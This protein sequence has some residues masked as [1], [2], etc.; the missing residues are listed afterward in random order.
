MNYIKKLL[1]TAA[2][3][4][5]PLT[6]SAQSS[7]DEKPKE[8]WQNLDLKADGA[9]GISTDKAYNELLK[10]KTSK[11]VVVAVIDGGIDEN[12]EDLKQVMWINAKEIAGNGIDDDKNGYIDD[13]YGWNFIGSAKGLNIHHD[14]MEVVRL[15]NKLQPKYAAALNST[16]FTEAE[17]KEFQLYKK[18]VTDYMEKLQQAQ[19]G[20]QNTTLI[21][22]YLNE[23]LVKMGKTEPTIEDFNAYKAAGDIESQVVKFLKP[24]IKKTSYKEFRQELEDGLKHYDTQIKYH[25]NLEFDPRKDSVGDNYANS[26]EKFYGNNDI[27][28]PDAEHGTHVAG[29]IGAVRGNSLGIKG[30]ADNVKIMALRTVPDGDER[31]KDVANSIRYAVDNGAKVINMSFGKAYSWDKKVVDEAVKY[32]VSKDVLLVHAA[33]NDGK[34]TEKEDNVPNRLFADSTGVTMGTAEGWIEVGASGWNNDDELVASFSNYGGKSVDVFAPG[35]KINSTMPDS[36]YKDNDGTSMASPVVA[37]LAA[38]IRSYY[39][40]FTA[41]QVKEIIMNSVTK[42]EQKVK[43]REEG[44]SNKVA[45]SEISVSGGVV[46]A[47]NALLLAEKT[48]STA[49]V[50]SK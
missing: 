46:N 7:A 18:L 47:Y 24:E 21:L 34:N 32:A 20:L 10:G 26:N 29:I 19:M 3:F 1:Y 22:K 4:A 6:S 23:I 28:G 30:I 8:N 40:Q 2:V 44:S 50:K 5:L 39:P 13:I 38:L 49:S 36:K 11:T 45:I 31:D 27:T 43:I 9:F 37:G 15:V 17:R 25:L 16:P 42:V 41:V 33:G 35:V 14:N 12:H 48:N